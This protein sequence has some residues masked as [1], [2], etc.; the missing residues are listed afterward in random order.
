MFHK[1]PKILNFESLD[2]RG[3]KKFQ[4]D[5]EYY[6]ITEKVDGSNCSVIF[7]LKAPKNS[8]DRIKIYTR[9]GNQFSSEVVQ[10]I[11]PLFESLDNLLRN[12]SQ[13]KVSAV[14]EPLLQQASKVSLFGEVF[15]SRIMNR[16]DYGREIDFVAFYIEI[17]ANFGYYSIPVSFVHPLLEK[18]GIKTIPCF[19]YKT[20]DVSTIPSVCRMQ[21]PSAFANKE[22]KDK[23]RS[24]LEGYVV[25]SVYE[26][27][28][29]YYIRGMAKIKDKNFKDVTHRNVQKADPLKSLNSEF[30]GY[31]TENRALDTLSKFGGTLSKKDVGEFIGQVIRDAMESFAIDHQEEI[32]AAKRTVEKQIYRVDPSVLEVVRKTAFSHVKDS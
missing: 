27:N 1:F 22:Q 13:V 30:N 24:F 12:P 32:E 19:V 5:C 11:R 21:V 28:K 26:Y 4:R 15:G 7:D 31:I 14:Y 20:S 8:E 16:I 29:R 3:L 25:Y 18:A 10:V 23:R 9:N 2:Q 17:Y 6:L